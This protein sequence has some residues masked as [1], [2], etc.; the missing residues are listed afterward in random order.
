MDID[1]KTPRRNPKVKVREEE[2]GKLLLFSGLPLLCIN[3]D[4][5]KIWDLCDGVNSVSQVIE[6]CARE[7]KNLEEA[8]D[9]VV[10]FV[11]EALRL[12]LITL[13]G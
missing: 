1:N 11:E 9:G 3:K 7:T 5:E 12:D 13:E 10:D 2:F 4:A 8:R 6:A